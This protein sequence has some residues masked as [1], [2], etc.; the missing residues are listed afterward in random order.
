MQGILY[1]RATVNET[2]LEQDWDSLN[3]CHSYLLLTQLPNTM[4]YS[5]AGVSLHTSDSKQIRDQ[6][7]LAQRWVVQTTAEQASTLLVS[8][9]HV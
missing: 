1:V 9:I 2:D 4:V 6:W 7:C 3:G 8:T 5:V